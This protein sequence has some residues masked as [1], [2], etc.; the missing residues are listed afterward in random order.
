MQHYIIGSEVRRRYVD[1]EP[2]ISSSYINSQVF[3]RSTNSKLAFESLESQLLGLYPQ[4][5]WDT[6]MSSFQQKNALPPF[7]FEGMQ[8]IINELGEF[9]LPDWI[10]LPPI[11][12]RSRNYDF[13]LGIHD[14]NCTGFK[15]LKNELINSTKYELLQKPYIDLLLP[16]FKS[17]SF[18]QNICPDNSSKLWSQSNISN[19]RDIYNV[20]HE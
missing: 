12:S 4:K 13:K 1:S 3:F 20:V 6:R 11:F 5:E 8:E 17:E 14:S 9:P 15:Q 2:L 18:L 10:V 7:E 19:K 16:I